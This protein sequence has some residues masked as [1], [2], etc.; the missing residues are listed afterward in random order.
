MRQRGLVLAVMASLFLA[1]CESPTS[2]A[3]ESSIAGNVDPQIALVEVFRASAPCHPLGSRYRAP[4]QGVEFHYRRSDGSR[5]SRRIVA[6]DKGLVSESLRILSGPSNR[7][8]HRLPPP[9]PRQTI[10]GM[11]SVTGRGTSGREISYESPIFPAI[12]ALSIGESAT[13]GAIET[14]NFGRR[15]VSVGVPTTVKFETCGTVRV[16]DDAYVVRAYRISTAGRSFREG[17]FDRVRR[18]EAVFYLSERD[19]FPLIY[20]SSND[21]MVVDAIHR[22]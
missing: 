13:V 20:Q 14:T 9:I 12:S 21:L 7:A 6:V 16:G 19:G 11:I 22:P 17:K 10:A 18:S 8:L 3:Q 1:S 5:I 2:K 15:R 4:N